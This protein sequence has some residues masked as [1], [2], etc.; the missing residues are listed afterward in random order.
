LKKN[1]TREENVYI[2]GTESSG[3]ERTGGVKDGEQ[4]MRSKRKPTPIEPRLI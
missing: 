1:F 4:E 3:G 2:I